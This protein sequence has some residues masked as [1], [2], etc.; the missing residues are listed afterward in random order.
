MAAEKSFALKAAV[1]S[2]KRSEG[3]SA[4]TVQGPKSKVQSPKRRSRKWQ[5]RRIPEGKNIEH[6]MLITSLRVAP[7][8][9]PIRV[10]ATGGQCCPWMCQR[11]ERRPSSRRSGER[12]SPHHCSNGHLSNGGDR[13]STRLNS[14]HIPL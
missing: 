14:S 6:R 5:Q 1:P 12:R 13:K 3:E 2:W 8:L 11:N 9:V 4:F 10:E 7:G